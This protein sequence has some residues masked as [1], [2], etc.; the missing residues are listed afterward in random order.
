[1]D[2]HAQRDIQERGNERM[3]PEDM[4]MH[5]L[6]KGERHLINESTEDIFRKRLVLFT[7]YLAIIYM[8]VGA[9]IG[10]IIGVVI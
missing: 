9:L 1:M 4:L 5:F 6:L 7:G 10:F 3:T 2:R 8:L